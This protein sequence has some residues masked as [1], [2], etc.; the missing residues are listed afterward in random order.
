MRNPFLGL[1]ASTALLAPVIAAAASTLS[2]GS[3]SESDYSDLLAGPSAECLAVADNED[4]T[5]IDTWAT[6][7][8]KQGLIDAF[9][10]KWSTNLPPQ[11]SAHLRYDINITAVDMTMFTNSTLSLRGGRPRPHDQ[12]EKV[13]PVCCANCKIKKVN[14]VVCKKLVWMMPLL[15]IWCERWKHECCVTH[16]WHHRVCQCQCE[17]HDACVKWA[18]TYN[19]GK[20]TLLNEEHWWN[21]NDKKPFK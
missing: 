9:N 16:Y 2:F 13:N 7:I 1:L 18:K 15:H 10:Q 21:P 4:D 8:E 14:G 19:N 12:P 20:C 5:C 11:I 17:G 3:L 6:A